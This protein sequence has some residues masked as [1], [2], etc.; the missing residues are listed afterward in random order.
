[1]FLL[2]GLGL[3]SVPSFLLAL[4]QSPSCNA[5][6]LYLIW[7][8]V[9]STLVHPS[10]SFIW[11]LRLVQL[12]PSGTS[13][14]DAHELALCQCFLFS[15]CVM[16]FVNGSFEKEFLFERQA[17]REGHLPYVGSLSNWLQTLGLV[18]N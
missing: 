8:D 14:R 2:T 11:F 10:N 5:A 17:M 15:S 18:F 16:V 1:M 6:W 7:S 4:P 9:L 3:L 12:S 13:T